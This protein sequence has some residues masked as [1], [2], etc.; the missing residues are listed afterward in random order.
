V[1]IDFHFNFVGFH[2]TDGYCHLRVAQKSSKSKLVIVCSQYKNYYG[3]S[4]TNAIELIVEKLFYDIVSKKIEGINLPK[5]VTY[6]VW[7]ED[8]NLLDKLLV[9]INPLKY[10]KRFKNELLDIPKMFK[11]LFWIERYPKGT[12]LW[13]HE[14]NYN[15]VTMGDQ[16]D[17]HWHGRPS[18]ELIRNETGFSISEL[19]ADPELLDLKLAKKELDELDLALKFISNKV[20]R[21]VRW[22]Q[23]IL[24]QLPSRIKYT[25]FSTGTLDDDALWERDIQ[26]L[27]EEIFT[28]CFPARDLFGSEFKVSKNLG[29]YNQGGEK[30][31]DLVI[32]EPDSNLP[33]VMIELK[34]ACKSSKNQ[35]STISQDIAKLLLYSK[36]IKS[37]TYLIIC[38]N[39]N[40][41]NDLADALS[42]ILSF[43]NESQETLDTHYH[44]KDLKLTTEYHNLLRDYGIHSVYSRLIGI[45]D[46][47]TVA[48]WQISH[49]HDKLINNKPYLYRLVKP[50]K[51]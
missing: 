1:I 23:E 21:P 16:N 37:D 28:I 13:A 43:N 4:P 7:H 20:N 41:L 15:R 42:S 8:V 30:E 22:T 39:K 44:A 27:I 11:D 40:E 6:E 33:S 32:F 48:I 46:D 12:G 34:R 35:I 38:G 3:T 10:K 5:I 24:E 47:R 31:C 49:I 50:A 9:A 51:E 19:F 17:P 26:K 25:K 14:D 36:V 2:G 29:I 18:D 45:S